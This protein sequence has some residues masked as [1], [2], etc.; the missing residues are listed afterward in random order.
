MQIVKREFN[1]EVEEKNITLEELKNADE[2]FVCGTGSEIAGV[3]QVE[4]QVIRDAKTGEWTEK[5]IRLY[6]DIVH[7]R[8]EKYRDWITE[9]RV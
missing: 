9:V 1:L 6:D 2:V 8:N 7:G 4:D 3:V 5:I